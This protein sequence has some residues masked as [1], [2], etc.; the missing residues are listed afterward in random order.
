MALLGI[1]KGGV[2]DLD[3][4][5]SQRYTPLT[6]NINNKGGTAVSLGPVQGIDLST[7]RGYVKVREELKQLRPRFVISHPQTNTVGHGQP[8]L[9]MH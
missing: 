5:T 4:L 2:T 3:E 9:I 6:D 1:S 7:V 8:N